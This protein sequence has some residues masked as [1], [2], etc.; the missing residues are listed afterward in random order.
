MHKYARR[1]AAA[2]FLAALLS[3]LLCSCSRNPAESEGKPIRF[4]YQNRIGS[5]IPVIAIEKGFFAANGLEVEAY[6]F[7]SG[8]ACAETLYTGAVDIAAMGD[9][10][11]LI[12]LA[13]NTKL[14]VLTSHASGEHRHRLMVGGNAPYTD[15]A[16]LQGKRIAVKKGT[17]TYG[18][19]L[20]YLEANALAPGD[21]D[22]VNLKPATMPEALSSGSVDAFAASEPT[23]SL[24]QMHGAHELATFGNLGNNYP[25]MILTGGEFSCAR[26]EEMEKFLSA[27]HDA[28][29][30][31]RANYSSAVAIM[32]RKLNMPHETTARAMQRHDFTLR[33]D[34]TTMASL[35]NTAEFLH[36]E[37]VINAVP[38]L[39]ICLE[40]P[41]SQD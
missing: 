39:H 5:A 36:A 1:V 28:E 37:G 9:S 34:R 6:P 25:I 8:P 17:S 18:G 30:F 19:L 40:P 2:V 31:I 22:L 26:P 27:L 33:L 3:N 15:I 23:T 12:S 20:K 21:F 29:A 10:T 14:C 13:R 35:R 41:E 4:A 7:N 32:A 38:Q 16:S 11:A 24:A